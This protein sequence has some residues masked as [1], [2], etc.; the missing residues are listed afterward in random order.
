MEN[1]QLATTCAPRSN[2]SELPNRSTLLRQWVTKFALNAGTALTPDA[3]GVYVELWA[4]GFSD[5][6]DSVFDAAC[7]KA[8]RTAKFWPVK[9]ADIRE[10]VTHAERNAADQLA[11][12][13]W[14]EVLN[15]R[16]LHWSPDAPGGFYSGT[17]V[18][19]ERLSTAARAAGVFREHDTT[20]SLHVWSKK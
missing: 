17:P 10:Q 18:M 13:A 19:S 7:R 11:E 15:I 8:I 20:E 12:E 4:E 16:R 1:Q 2:P 3:F 14:R 5:L 6:P 9:I